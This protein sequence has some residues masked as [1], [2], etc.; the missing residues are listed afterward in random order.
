[1]LVSVRLAGE[2]DD[3]ALATHDG[4]DG[5]HGFESLRVRV[6]ERIVEDDG[7]TAV[8]SDDRRAR[9]PRN[10]RDLL[11][12]WAPMLRLLYGIVRPRECSTDD[13]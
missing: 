9:Q 4:Q 5:P 10:E 8:G 1:M 7:D 12:S 11:C 3:L 6:P 2:H 13:R